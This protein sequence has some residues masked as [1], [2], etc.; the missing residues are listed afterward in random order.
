MNDLQVAKYVQVIAPAAIVDDASFTT[1]EIDTLDY[2]YLT[3]VFN[4]G[5]TDIAMA[6]LKMQS[7]DA[8][9]SGFADVTGLDCNGDTDIDGSAAAL[10]SATDDNSLVVFQVDLRGQK[11]YFDLV[12]TAGNG[13]TGSFGSAVA[14]LSKGA[15]SAVTSAA[16]GAETVLRV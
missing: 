5:A 10:P 1:N 7:S 11:R 13:S 3:V 4:L 16:M 12:A 9:G 8:S 14:I 6:A 2:D 15:V